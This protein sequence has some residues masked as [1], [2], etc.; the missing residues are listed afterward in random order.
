MENGRSNG[1]AID[2]QPIQP[3][4]DGRIATALIV[5]QRALRDY[6][7]QS[8]ASVLSEEQ[9]QGFLDGVCKILIGAPNPNGGGPNYQFGYTKG[10]DF[11]ALYEF[12]LMQE[13]LGK[14]GHFTSPPKSYQ[15]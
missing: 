12:G 8:S 13:Y 4:L 5:A 15:L 7:T 9:I 1:H 3:G 14:R 6:R 2:A 10:R 11:A